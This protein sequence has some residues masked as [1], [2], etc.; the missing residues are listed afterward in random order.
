MLDTASPGRRSFLAG[1]A[2]TVLLP[3]ITGTAGAAGGSIV[4]VATVGEPGLLDPMPVTADLI[5]EIDQHFYETLYINDPAFRFHPLLAAAMPDISGDG[6]TY[7]IPLR[8]GVPFHDGSTMTADDVIA[9]L[10]RWLRVS[11]RGRPLAPTVVSVAAK[12]PDAVVITLKAPYAPLLS[13]L[14]T[15]N[16]GPTVMPAAIANGSDLL[17]QFIGT[18]PYKLL[19]H[20]PDTY[21]RLGKFDQYASPPGAPDGYAGSRRPIIDELR[22]IPVPNPTTRAD[23]LL[24]GQYDFADVLTPQAYAQLANQQKVKRGLVRPSVWAILIM[25]TKAGLMSNVTMRRAVQA[26]VAPADMMAA[27]FG[28]PTL[29]SLEGSLYAQGTAWY[30][31]ETPGYNQNDPKQ[32]AAL[33]KQAGYAGQPI[34]ILTTT[35]YD[36]MYKIGQVAQANLQDAGA[37][38][39]LQVMDWA[40]LLQKRQNPKL[41]E[42][43]ITSTGV[44]T[45]PATFNVLNASYPGWWDTPDKRA[46]F[47][48]FTTETDDAKRVELWKKLQ[49]L[50]YAEVPTVKIGS[51]YYLYGINTRLS[52]YL[53]E[54]WPA[55]WNVTAS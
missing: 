46:A 42:A 47:D 21:I 44:P 22:F 43:F 31:P 14:G 3:A 8:T 34:R 9:T 11:P 26:A 2:A 50:F 53:P 54:Q 49:A 39:D 40:T 28:D 12:G 48:A 35:Q 5:S 51:F 32:A 55:F 25:N 16:A 29:W 17:T 37:K 7:T 41:W 45:D 38:V 52:G 30:D 13:V 6:T 18:G 27:A 15:P 19:E 10:K 23:G 20:K 24:S 1:A 4:N 33:L 36:Y